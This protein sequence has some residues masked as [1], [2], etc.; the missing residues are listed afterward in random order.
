MLQVKKEVSEGVGVGEGSKGI[1]VFNYIL[2]HQHDIQH[3]HGGVLAA[4]YCYSHAL[5]RPSPPTISF[6]P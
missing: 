1:M 5:N 4:G 2:I 3:D 6:K